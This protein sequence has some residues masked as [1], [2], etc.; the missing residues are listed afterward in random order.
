MPNIY[1]IYLYMG[2]IDGFLRSPGEVERSESRAGVLALARRSRA[3]AI[4]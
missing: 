3:G 1:F 4:G 2:Y